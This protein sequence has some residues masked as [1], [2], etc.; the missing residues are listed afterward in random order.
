MTLILQSSTLLEY[1]FQLS[2]FKMFKKN[3]CLN[4]NF[5]IMLIQFGNVYKMFKQIVEEGAFFLVL[6]DNNYAFHLEN[7]VSV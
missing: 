3:L 4:G 7:V 5:Y 1:T 2:V 6:V